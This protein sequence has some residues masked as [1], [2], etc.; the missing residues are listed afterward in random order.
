VNDAKHIIYQGDNLMLKL[1]INLVISLIITS[2]HKL[3]FCKATILF[4]RSWVYIVEWGGPG[5]YFKIKI[6][7]YTKAENKYCRIRFILT[8]STGLYSS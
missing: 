3:V 6:I 5:V 1:A 2:K 8:I 4:T 7:K